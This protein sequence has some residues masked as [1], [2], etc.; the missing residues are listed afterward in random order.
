MIVSYDTALFIT[1]NTLVFN[2]NIIISEKIRKHG[3]ENILLNEVI[4]IFILLSFYG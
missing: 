2:I 3:R 4:S 1:S